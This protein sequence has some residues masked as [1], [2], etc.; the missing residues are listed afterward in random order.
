MT[1]EKLNREYKKLLSITGDSFSKAP[2]YVSLG[3][4]S[5]HYPL[6][7]NRSQTEFQKSLDGLVSSKGATWSVSGYLENRTTILRDF[8]GM[9][10]EKRVY[11]LAVDLNLPCGTRLY[12]PHDCEVVLSEYEEGPGQFGGMLVLKVTKAPGKDTFYMQIGHLNPDT[13]PALGTGLKKGETFGNVGDMS[14]NGDWFHH[15]HFQI[16]TAKGY[17]EGW[18]HKGYCK[19]SDLPRIKEFCPDPFSYL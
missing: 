4:D 3:E 15:I 19:E 16:L 9:I 17:D 11:H 6:F 13:L 18:L 10:Q 2:L 14:Q 12:A 7:A 1:Q 8:P 5:E